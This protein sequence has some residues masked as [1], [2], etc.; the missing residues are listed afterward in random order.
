MV[1]YAIYMGMGGVMIY[2]NTTDLHNGSYKVLR[3]QAYGPPP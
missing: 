2:G 3:A 1:A